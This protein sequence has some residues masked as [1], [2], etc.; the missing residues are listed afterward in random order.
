[1]EEGHKI[2]KE[3]R[4]NTGKYVRYFTDDRSHYINDIRSVKKEKKVS[5]IQA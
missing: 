1:V 5:T 2:I 3:T 4:H